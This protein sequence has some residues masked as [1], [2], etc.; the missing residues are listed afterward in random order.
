MGGDLGDMAQRWLEGE[1]LPAN[2][3][4]MHATDFL[5]LVG[6]CRSVRVHSLGSAAK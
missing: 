4:A 5:G 1:L 6:R 3:W 2:N